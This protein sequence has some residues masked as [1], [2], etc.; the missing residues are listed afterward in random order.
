MANTNVL[1]A[2]IIPLVVAFLFLLLCAIFARFRFRSSAQHDPALQARL[3]R[4]NG[5][6]DGQEDRDVAVGEY[7]ADG[8]KREPAGTR[9]FLGGCESLIHPY[10]S[11]CLQSTV[12][13]YIGIDIHR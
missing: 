9:S 12:L 11:R 8:G 10:L 3:A 6:E 1:L 13:L 7:D 2:I 5:K 4:I